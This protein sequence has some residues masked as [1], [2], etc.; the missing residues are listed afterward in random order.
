MD[1]VDKKIIR[2]LMQ[3]SKITNSKIAK[4]IGKSESATLERVRRL[5]KTGIIE[6]Y[7]IYV[8]PKQVE[9]GLELFITMTLKNTD[10]MHQ[11]EL[12]IQQM[13]EVLTFA[14]I[15]GR[16]DFLAHVAVKNAEELSNFVNQKLIPLG[17]IER[18][19]SMTVLNM[20]KR[21]FPPL[22]TTD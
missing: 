10:Y 22:P 4:L 13:D 1:K 15:L 12:A 3:D 2:L 7:S 14:Q 11:F 18:I 9:R 8:S 19:E 16:S 6:G 21:N 20:L 5:E 17:Y